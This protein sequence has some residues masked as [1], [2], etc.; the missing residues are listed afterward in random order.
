[1]NAGF[2]TVE[3]RDIAV[4]LHRSYNMLSRVSPFLFYWALP[5]YI[6]FRRCLKSSNMFLF[7]T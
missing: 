4:G 3:L 5:I 2:L 6:V 7:V 1:M